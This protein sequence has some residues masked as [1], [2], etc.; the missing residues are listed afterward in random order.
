MSSPFTFEGAV[1]WLGALVTLALYSVLYRE[2]PIYRVAEHVFLGLA[3]GYGLYVVTGSGSWRWW[4]AGCITRSTAS[5]SP[6]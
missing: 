2:N 6:G 4:P 3:T 5:G 1:I